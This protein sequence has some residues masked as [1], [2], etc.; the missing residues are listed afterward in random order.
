[1]ND[2]DSVSKKER[3]KERKKEKVRTEGVLRLF[4]FLHGKPVANFSFSSYP[5]PRHILVPSDAPLR[6][7][8]DPSKGLLITR[9]PW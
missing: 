3:K 2:T 7:G 9:Q 5:F 8:F 6:T 4:P 1:M